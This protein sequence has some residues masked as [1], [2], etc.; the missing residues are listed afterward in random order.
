[1]NLRDWLA[2]ILACEMTPDELDL[3][4][5][6]ESLELLEARAAENL[7]DEDQASEIG[8]E[9]AQ[10]LREMAVILARLCGDLDAFLDTLDFGRVCDAMH[11]AQ[12]L[13]DIQAELSSL[14]CS[15]QTVF[16]RS[17]VA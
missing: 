11:R 10:K 13:L 15:A 2:Q 8:G 16:Q 9:A 6:E 1:M 14:V 4:V 12:R 3:V 7:R 17:L 5:L